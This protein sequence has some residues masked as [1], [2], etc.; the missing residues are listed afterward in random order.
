MISILNSISSGELQVQQ[1]PEVKPVKEDSII[2][3]LQNS[4]IEF[5]VCPKQ[6]E[7]K[8]N[9]IEFEIEFETKKEENPPESPK[10]PINVEQILQDA[11]L[12]CSHSSTAEQFNTGFG[13]NHDLYYEAICKKPDLKTPLYLE[14]YLSEFVSEEEKAAARHALGLYNKGDV[15]AMSL[16]TA[17]NKVPSK[18]D[19]LEALSLQMRKGDKFFTPMTS[20]NAVFDSEG[21]TLTK[22]VASLNKLILE[23]QNEIN[24]INKVSNSKSITSLG[25]VRVFLDGFSN[26]DNLHVTIDNINKEMLR[27]EAIN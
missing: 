26:G 7:P 24:K 21:N 9:P 6:E 16:L 19:W 11:Q 3:L 5:N 25:D 8:F 1:A 12:Q 17:E 18:E 13:E 4:E 2:D 20:F 14:N 10:E 15:V 23:Q 27:F 22:T